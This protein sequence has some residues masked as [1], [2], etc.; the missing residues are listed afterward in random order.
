MELT[1][2]RRAWLPADT[3]LWPVRTLP[4]PTGRMAYTDTGS[5]PVVLLVHVGFWSFIWRDLIRELERDFR[6][7]TFDSPG[8]G[9]SDRMNWR[10]ASHDRACD[11][12]SALVDALELDRVTLIVHDV[13][14]P[15]GLAAVATKPERVTGIVAM[16]TYAWRPSIAPFRG[17]IRLTG[18][19]PV[20]LV[21]AVSKFIPRLTACRF[22]AGRRWSA[23]D[24]STFRRGLDG[25]A[26][27]VWHRYIQDSAH[28]TDVYDRAEGAIAGQLADRPMM[29]IFGRWADYLRFQSRWR[30]RYPAA[31]KRVVA[32]GNH[33]PMGDAPRHVADWICE[34]HRTSTRRNARAGVVD[35][36]AGWHHHVDRAGPGRAKSCGFQRS[37]Q[38]GPESQMAA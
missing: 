4:T 23:A 22:G 8:V 19:G 15:V 35:R 37:K 24:R 1:V 18:S 27:R 10:Q 36:C 12:L 29:T 6:I 26:V 28:A 7:V 2:E 5:G 30:A 33:F 9:L 38:V 13:G 20:R 25:T 3:W 32:R 34:W 31:V 11:E 14:G 21:D 17:F 16:N